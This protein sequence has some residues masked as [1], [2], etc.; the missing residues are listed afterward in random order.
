MS[1]IWDYITE[2][3]DLDED[4]GYMVSEEVK[5]KFNTQCVYSHC[6]GFDSPGY[7]IDCYA[8]AFINEDGELEL[9]DYTIECC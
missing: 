7:D 9:Y 1:K 3:I 6:G 8:I 4:N 2:R 5:E